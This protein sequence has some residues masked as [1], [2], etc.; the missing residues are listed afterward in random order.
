MR[1]ISRTAALFLCLF[2]AC[3]LSYAG[4]VTIGTADTG[5]CYPFMCNDSGTSVGQS[6]D[7]QQVFTPSAFSAP[8]TIDAITWYFAS[9]FGGNPVAIGGSYTFYLGYSNS[10]V[11]G[12]S[13]NLTSNVMSETFLGTGTIPAGG[14][15]DN[16]VLSLSGF[17]PFTYDPTLAPLLLEIVVT[18]QDNVPNFSGN[19]YNEADS[20]GLVT[21]RAYCTTNVGCFADSVGLV[22]TF[23]T[24]TTATPEPSSLLLLG[25]SLAGLAA[26]LSRKLS[27]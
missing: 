27:A 20:S 11:G 19:G 17:A 9:V 1:T 15:N 22:T 26:V 10:P 18:N 8:V 23:D 6:I 2:T 13:A 5:N 21:S 4:S 12:L 3:G 7:L 25:T 16:P 24:T 14:I